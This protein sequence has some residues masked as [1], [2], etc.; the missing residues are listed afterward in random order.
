MRGTWSPG[1]PPTM[2]PPGLPTGRWHLLE[3]LTS[4]LKETLRRA[5]PPQPPL[6]SFQTVGWRPGVSQAR[7]PKATQ[8]NSGVWEELR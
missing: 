2:T 3:P 1:L 6:C 8:D 4:A 7:P 5:E